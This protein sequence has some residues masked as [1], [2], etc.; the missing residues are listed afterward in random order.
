[1]AY[2]AK[3]IWETLSEEEKEEF[4]LYEYPP[5]EEK[6][7]L[8]PQYMSREKDI[9]EFLDSTE[10][11]DVYVDGFLSSLFCFFATKKDFK[12]AALYYKMIPEHKRL[13]AYQS[14]FGCLIDY[15][16]LSFEEIDELN[17]ELDK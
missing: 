16:P 12:R 17:K 10:K 6:Y 8:F 4:L 9:R 2:T 3:E 13:E 11:N 15:W 14:C 7:I 5:D 1:M